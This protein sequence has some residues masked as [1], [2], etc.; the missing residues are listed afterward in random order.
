VL[1]IKEGSFIGQRFRQM[2]ATL[3]Q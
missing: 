1:T 3:F 2:F